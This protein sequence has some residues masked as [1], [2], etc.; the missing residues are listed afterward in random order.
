MIDDDEKLNKLARDQYVRPLPKRFYKIVEVT[1][2]LS[3]ALDGRKVKTPM[4]ASLVL[5]TRSLA[6]AVAEEWRAQ[7][8]V[9][10]PGIMPL[11]R[12]A[13]TA[14]DRATAERANIIN[15]LVGYANSD[16]VCYR[17]ETPA[18]LAELQ[19]NAWDLIVQWAEAKLACKINTTKGIIHLAQSQ[20]MLDA[21]RARIE[22]C[23]A[24]ELTVLYNLATLTSS[25]LTA[26]MLLDGAL[27]SEKG[28]DAAHIDE[29]FQI[30]QW[31]YDYQAI[32][33]REGRLTDYQAC[34]RYLALSR[35]EPDLV[36]SQP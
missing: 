29:D 16:A 15:E 30:S 5:S 4:K 36:T 20:A 31:G 8:E 35:G 1:D 23:N 11:T 17:A 13:N 10:H 18:D 3:I 34:L 14:I 25:V 28:W 12:Y 24:N 22:S 33:R 27:T 6:E 21:V 7:V 26:L 32:K 2:D 19:R 9:I